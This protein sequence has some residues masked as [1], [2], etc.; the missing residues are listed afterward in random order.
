[1][2][3]GERYAK[4]KR[5][6]I[7]GPRPARKGRGVVVL[8]GKKKGGRG[9]GGKERRYQKR[10]TLKKG[11]K[12]KR[13]DRNPRNI[14]LASNQ[15]KKGKRW[16]DRGFRGHGLKP[17]KEKSRPKTTNRKKGTTSR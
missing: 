3:E 10:A 17:R 16:Q 6:G 15:K 11:N 14:T 9:K 2:P 12:K 8:S 4:E 1:L 7:Q 13:K 5:E